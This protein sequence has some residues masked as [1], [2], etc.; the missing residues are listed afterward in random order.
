MIFL[1]Q[2]VTTLGSVLVFAVIIQTLLSYFM[3]PYH[4]LRS[5]LDRLIDPLLRPI[6]NVVPPLGGLDFSPLVLVILIQIVESL[7]VQLLRMLS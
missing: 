3:S 4:P 5:A 7:L 6:R 1:I 2:L